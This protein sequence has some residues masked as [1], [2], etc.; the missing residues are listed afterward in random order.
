MDHTRFIKVTCEDGV[1]I[2]LNIDHIQGFASEL[3]VYQLSMRDGSV[4]KITKE[5][6]E[7][8]WG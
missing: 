7:E 2:I 6:F 8:F 5:Q 4:M 3:D 1:R